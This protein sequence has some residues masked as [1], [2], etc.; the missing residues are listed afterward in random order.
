MVFEVKHRGHSTREEGAVRDDRPGRDGEVDPVAGHALDRIEQFVRA[1]AFDEAVDP[2]DVVLVGHDRVDPGRDGERGAVG[3]RVGV[4][5]R[6]DEIGVRR[7]G[8]E[9]HGERQRERTQ[10][11]ARFGRVERRCCHRGRNA[12]TGSMAPNQRGRVDV[13]T[14]VTGG[15]HRH[16]RR[17]AHTSAARRSGAH[18]SPGSSPSS[19]SSSRFRARPAGSGPSRPTRVRWRSAR[20]SFGSAAAAVVLVLR[21]TGRR[22]Y[23]GRAPRIQ[24]SGI[25]GR[26]FAAEPSWR[27]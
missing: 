21:V 14:A 9:T 24:L 1:S 6:V 17:G 25:P 13:V 26:R 10:R 8:R 15:A 4:D 12:C 19:P 27:T 16:P 7:S 23:A 11:T 3:D 22:V 2:G 5:R 20:T 18:A